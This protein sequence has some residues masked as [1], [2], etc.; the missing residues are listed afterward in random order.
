MNSVRKHRRPLF[1]FA[2]LVIIAC[3]PKMIKHSGDE[4]M[5]GDEPVIEDSKNTLDYGYKD[6]KAIKNIWPRKDPAVITA[7]GDVALNFATMKE[8]LDYRI[9]KYGKKDAMIYP[10]SKVSKEIKG[11]G[12]CNLESPITNYDIKSFNDKDEVFYFSSPGGSEDI[13]KYAGFDVASLANNHVKDAGE[14]GMFDTYKRLEKI[15]I[16]PVGVGKDISAALKPVFTWHRGTRVAI[17]AF[18]NV[19]PKSVWAGPDRAGTA[20]GSDELLC[21]AVK[22]VRGEV[23]AVVVSIHWGQEVTSDY[24]VNQPEK[25]QVELGHK[26]IDAGASCIIGH[27]SHGLGPVERYKNGIIFYSLGDFVF[28]GRHSAAHRTSMLVRVSLSEAGLESYTL[29]PVNINPLEVKYSPEI[30]GRKS[31]ASVIDRVLTVKD[32]KYS[33]YYSDDKSAIGSAE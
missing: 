32:D 29:I 11:I 30:L 27:Q 33:D 31:G 9:S 10:F 23:D 19:V 13:L 12:F 16:A 22:K 5:K 2:L 3:T 6:S 24:P 7:V 28:A 14:E 21:A 25:E 8:I 17:F 4:I 15:N 1:L 18:N 20:G 26:L